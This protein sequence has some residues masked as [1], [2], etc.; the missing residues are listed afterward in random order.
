MESH[1]P[2][3]NRKQGHIHVPVGILCGH[4]SCPT[5][6]SCPHYLPVI[7]CRT[8]PAL[9][10][11]LDSTDYRVIEDTHM[12]GE[13]FMVPSSGRTVTINI[14][15]HWTH[16]KQN[17]TPLTSKNWNTS[18]HIN[19]HVTGINN[20][21]HVPFSEWSTQVKVIP[22]RWLSLNLNKKVPG[23]LSFSKSLSFSLLTKP[24]T[25]LK[26]EQCIVLS[27]QRLIYDICIYFIHKEQT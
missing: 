2:W 7:D 21:Y 4:S 22:P 25:Y 10:C 17:N 26:I 20:S 3:K 23:I 13:K 11:S 18:N 15:I 8:M 1:F 5:L 6:S 16:G 9:L 14:Q 19:S 27:D 24:M 12:G